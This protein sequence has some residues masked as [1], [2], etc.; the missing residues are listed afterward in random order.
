MTPQ[1]TFELAIC[2]YEGIDG[3]EQDYMKAYSLFLEAAEAGCAEAMGFLGIMHYEGIVV[4]KDYH[5]AFKWFMF[6]AE[7]NLPDAQNNV[8]YMLKSGEGVEQNLQEAI[9]WYKLAAEQG[10]SEAQCD[11]AELYQYGNG[12][13]QNFAEA[14]KWYKLAAE[15]GHDGATAKLKILNDMLLQLLMQDAEQGDKIAQFKLGYKYHRGDGV[16][17][18]HVEAIK[19]YTLAAEQGHVKAQF[20][21]AYLYIHGRSVK[22]DTTE[23]VKWYK[24]AAEQGDANAQ[25][26]LAQSY[27]RGIGITQDY[28]ES[29]KWFGLA[30]EQGI[31]GAQYYIALMHESGIGV[32]KDMEK[33]MVWYT[34][35]AKQEYPGAM[36]RLGN[37]YYSNHDYEKAYTLYQKAANNRKSTDIDSI[38]MLADMHLSGLGCKKD[39]STAIKWLRKAANAGS[40]Q[41]KRKLCEIYLHAN[42]ISQYLRYL[43]QCTDIVSYLTLAELYLHGIHV[44]QNIYKAVNIWKDI[45]NQGYKC[46]HYN[47]AQAYYF[48]IG[49]SKNKA[50]AKKYL[51]EVKEY[52]LNASAFMD[53]ISQE[54]GSDVS[55]AVFRSDLRG[56]FKEGSILEAEWKYINAILHNTGS[57]YLEILNEVIG[58]YKAHPTKDSYFWLA[59]LYRELSISSDY[60]KSEYYF[61]KAVEADHTHAKYIKS[62]YDQDTPYS[63]YNLY[64]PFR[65]KDI[66]NSVTIKEKKTTPGLLLDN[67][68]EDLLLSHQLI[69]V[70]IAYLVVKGYTSLKIGSDVKDDF[71]RRY[72]DESRN[73]ADNC[74]IDKEKLFFLLSKRNKEELRDELIEYVWDVMEKDRIN[75]TSF[76]GHIFFEH[77]NSALSESMNI[78]VKGKEIRNIVKYMANNGKHFGELSP[79]FRIELFPILIMELSKLENFHDWSP[80]EHPK[81]D[82]LVYSSDFSSLKLSEE[83]QLAATNKITRTIYKEEYGISKFIILVN[84]EY[85]SSVMTKLHESRAKLIKDRV[86]ESVIELD[87]STFTDIDSSTALLVLNLDSPQHE[88]KFIK[89]EQEIVVSYSEL[90]KNEYILNYDIYSSPIFLNSD[91]KAIIRFY[92]LVV[93]EYEKLDKYERI[94]S[95][96]DIAFTS[97]LLNAISN[98]CDKRTKLLVKYDNGIK[99]HMLGN[100]DSYTHDLR[101][102]TLS[103]SEN[104]SVTSEYL[105]YILLSP[106]FQSYMDKIVDK[107]GYFTLSDLLYKKI[108]IHRDKNVQKQIIEEAV[109]RE[110]QRFGSGVE[111]NV[112]ILSEKTEVIDAF[113]DADGIALFAK[114]QS[115]EEIFNKHIKDDSKAIIDAIVIDKEH[116]E[117][118]DVMEEFGSIRDRNI[119]IYII[120]REGDKAVKGKK[121]VEYFINGNRIFTSDEESHKK[122]INKLRD[123]LDSSNSHQ[124]KIRMKYKD[125]FEAADALDKEY[126]KIGISAAILRYIQAGCIIEDD[127]KTSGPCATFREVCHELLKVFIDEKLIPQMDPGAIPSLLKLGTYYDNKASRQ[128]LLIEPFM[129]KSLSQSLEYFCKITNSSVHGSQD[130]SKLGTAA[131]NI[132]MEFIVWFYENLPLLKDIQEGDERRTKEIK[133]N[134]SNYKHM[135]FT[136]DEFNNGTDSY[137]YCENIHF[138]AKDRNFKLR[139]GMRVQIANNIKC[140]QIGEREYT[141]KR[142]NGTPIIYYAECCEYQDKR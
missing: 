23:S 75:T 60:V 81:I 76:P 6:A 95:N 112:A 117:Y 1:D 14:Q 65:F 133:I 4:A 77:L 62:L 131:L 113:G 67:F 82:T 22:H 42:D 66:L 13:E 57:S 110:R 28:I 100:S 139:K 90:E 108:A 118:E 53:R 44:S 114:S 137:F 105:A 130:S 35:S 36:R 47:L 2:Y 107:K 31:S 38:L 9:K 101:S 135:V 99:I 63:E 93:P 52:D 109:I 74:E 123:D 73:N 45:A 72:N 71:I 91:D 98:S 21:L 7:H 26:Y 46:A 40:E 136:L 116:D 12:I 142:V 55:S 5:E 39:K 70:Y 19:W 69:Y 20:N 92:D 89:D 51:Y 106:E 50:K 29:A 84:R 103:I 138:V 87:K 25:Y 61:E 58:I 27:Y 15:Q 68:P 140:E 111:F 43:H 8:A 83:S 119:H 59:R 121:K 18:D 16:R 41:A 78:I 24:A 54:E 129:H 30:A 128:Y 102:Y 56:C 86:L 11:L 80:W 126:P 88:V 141:R 33:A 124:A 115:F 104:S 97:S 79:R 96:K 85:C 10:H 32:E 94:I 120:S 3:K 17:R 132:L 134:Q 48:G 37:E 34:L 49:L 125:V 122:L 64:S 127:E